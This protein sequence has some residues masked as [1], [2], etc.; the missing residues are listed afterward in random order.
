[1][2]RKALVAGFIMLV[3]IDRDRASQQR[4]PASISIDVCNL[5]A[6][7]ALGD[8]FEHDL[9]WT[10]VRYAPALTCGSRADLAH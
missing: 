3:L 9:C 1:M 8:V 7:P 6:A 10:G 5:L 4:Q 2:S